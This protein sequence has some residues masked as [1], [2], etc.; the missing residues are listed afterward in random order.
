MAATTTEPTPKRDSMEATIPDIEAKL[1]STTITPQSKR[2]SLALTDLPPSVR[3]TIYKYALDTELANVGLPNVSFTHNLSPSG[4][5]AFKSSR[6]PFPVNTSLFYLNKEISRDALSYFYSKNLFIR[7]EIFTSDARHA[8]TMLEDSGVL[9]YTAPPDM[10]ER[11]TQHAM[12]IALVEKNSSMKRAIVMFPAQY[13]PRLINFIDQASRAAA[14]WAPSRT[15]FINVLHTYSYPVSR[16]QG[17]LLELFRLLTNIGGVTV[18]PKNLLPRYAEG[19]ST[20]MTA[21][22]FE[23]ENW[24][25]SVSELADLADAARE[26]GNDELAKEYGQAV[27]IALT[28]GYLTH[29]EALH[30]Q[31]GDAFHKAIQRL[32]WRTELGVGISLS[33]M[34]RATS[35]ARDWLN[36]ADPPSHVKTA[37]R[38]LLQA[39]KSISSALSLATDSP[40]PTHNP[41]FHSLPVE[42]IPPNKSSFFSD[43]ER[44][45]TWYALGTVHT[46]LGEFLFACGDFERA[47]ELWGPEGR[48]KIEGAFEKARKGI[49]G[50]VESMFEGKVRPGSGL[51]R[52]AVLARGV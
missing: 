24:L 15:L 23:A 19:L 32:R 36:A 25:Q 9:F 38:D 22:N 51:K 34:H 29:A 27:I 37:A 20:C 50:D 42:L 33:L 43:Q 31:D 46:A 2:R 4:M 6:P 11:S 41:W 49:D 48:E 39:E 13:L 45:Q 8:K 44:A 26:Q 7:F 1:A 28:Y 12:E 18:D 14:S 21:P 17:D 52:A 10:M 16:L 47:L 5:L 30:S 35:T 40:T 3:N